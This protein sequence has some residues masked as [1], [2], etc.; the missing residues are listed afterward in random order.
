MRAADFCIT[1]FFRDDRYVPLVR[2]GQECDVNF[3]AYCYFP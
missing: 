3:L 1:T 2:G